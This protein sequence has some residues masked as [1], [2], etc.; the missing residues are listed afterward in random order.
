MVDTGWGML[1]I[2]WVMAGKVVAVLSRDGE[3]VADSSS[4]TSL[5]SPFCNSLSSREAL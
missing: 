3:V 1:A 2:A 5:P 4:V